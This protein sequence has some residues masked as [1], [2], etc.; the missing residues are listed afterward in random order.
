MPLQ[1]LALKDRIGVVSVERCGPV[2][3][4]SGL[5]FPLQFHTVL[6]KNK[7]FHFI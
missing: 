1:R 7:A 4:D 2:L 5:S 6:V 3:L